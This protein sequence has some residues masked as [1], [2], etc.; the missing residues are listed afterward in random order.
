MLFVTD[1]QNIAASPAEMGDLM[2]S[3]PKKYKMLKCTKL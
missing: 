3:I 1:E 2:H